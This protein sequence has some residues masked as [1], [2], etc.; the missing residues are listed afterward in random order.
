MY[1]LEPRASTAKPPQAFSLNPSGNFD[2]NDGP[3]S[4]FIIRVGTPAQFFRVLPSTNS[5]ETLIPI[6]DRCEQGQSWCGNARGVEPFNGAAS[7]SPYSGS[8]NELFTTSLDP[9]KTC[10]AN[11]SPMCIN[12]IS[13]NGKCTDGAC[14]GRNC[15]GDPAGSCNGQGCNGLNGICTGPY[16]GCPCVGPDYNIAANSPSSAG[17]LNAVAAS[18]FQ[19]NLSSTWSSLGPHRLLADD[20]L[21][22]SVNGQYGT[23]RIGL[24]VEESGSLA[25]TDAL[26]AGIT[27]QPFYIGT[28][29]LKPANSTSVS[30]SPATFMTQLKQQ[31]LIPSLSYSYTAGAIYRKSDTCVNRLFG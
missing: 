10:T 23:D 4:T 28:F 6:P 13:V 2:G 9:G 11:R 8:P 16:I 30:K 31:N 29:G 25:L 18:G 22:T 12:C 3:W 15:C 14:A 24:G 1:Q 5:L 21:N 17:I 20:F 26:V 7:P 27:T 19:S